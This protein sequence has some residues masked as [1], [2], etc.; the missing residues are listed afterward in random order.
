MATTATTTTTTTTAST[1]G[2]GG[3]PSTAAANNSYNAHHP[4]PNFYRI[5]QGTSPTTAAAFLPGGSSD[6]D[7]LQAWSGLEA[8]QNAIEIAS[9]KLGNIGGVS[10]AH[11]FG[12]KIWLLLL[13]V[14][15]GGAE[16]A[17]CAVQDLAK[18][19]GLASQQYHTVAVRDL[20]QIETILESRPSWDCAIVEA[21]FL[22][23]QST[24]MKRSI[25]TLLSKHASE[26]LIHEFCFRGE[27]CTSPSVAYTVQQDMA[28]VFGM[29]FRPMTS[30]EWKSLLEDPSGTG[31]MA[32]EDTRNSTPNDS[33]T[34]NRMVVEQM[35]TGTVAFSNPIT[36][37]KDQGLGGLAKLAWNVATHEE[38]RDRVFEFAETLEE[39]RQ[40][41]G[42]ILLKATRQPKMK[43]LHPTE[44]PNPHLLW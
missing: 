4:R 12:C 42:Y 3:S 28:R 1:S 21:G 17:S 36:L 29:D 6:S 43:H 2:F 38:I 41:L 37:V 33:A 39:H 7:Q 34:T 11:R 8:G 40:H 25:L 31:M 15:E 32:L 10:L 20:N 26:L 22:T 27:A 19:Q 24:Q 23:H 5:L 30:D 14:P 35:E 13:D 44:K 16:E 9:N 18:Q